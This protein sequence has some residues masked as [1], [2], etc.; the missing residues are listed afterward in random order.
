MRDVMNARLREEMCDV[1]SAKM[2]NDMRD[3]RRDEVSA[4]RSAK[5]RDIGATSRLMRCVPR[6]MAECVTIS[7]PSER[8]DARQGAQ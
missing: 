1:M 2:R 8:W 3:E 5:A 4:Q 6:G 7:A